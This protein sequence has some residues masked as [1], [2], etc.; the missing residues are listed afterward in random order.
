MVEYCVYSVRS[1][2]LDVL[3]DW[4][5]FCVCRMVE[6]FHLDCVVEVLVYIHLDGVVGVLGYM[7]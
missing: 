1:E 7:V 6:V 2:H 5:F 3:Y 4:S